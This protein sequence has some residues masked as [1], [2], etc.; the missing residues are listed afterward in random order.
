ML[1][2]QQIKQQFPIFGQYP[3]LVYLDNASTTQKPA[4]VLDAERDFYV[5][6]NANVHRGVYGLAERADD[7]YELA[8]QT[9]ADF[10]G[11]KSGQIIF[12][13]NA[14]EAAN[15]LAFGIGEQLVK[16]GDNVIVTELEHHANFLPWQEMAA[17]KQAELRVVPFL[18]ES[19]ELDKLALDR[20]INDRTRVIAVTEMSNVLGTR[21][22]LN[23]IIEHAH[24]H[25]ALAV[26][27]AAQSLPHLHTDYGKLQADAVFFTGH[28]I[29]GPMG[30]GILYVSDY[31]AETMT[32]LLTGG[33]MI[34]ELPDLWLD[35]PRKFEAGTPNVAGLV[36]L[37]DALNFVKEIGRKEI[38][39]HENELAAR[40]RKMLET[41]PQVKMFV[42]Q[43]RS[44]Q[45]SIV[46]FDLEKVHPHD[47]AS[48][49]AEDQ[50]CIRAGHHCAKPLLK[51]LGRNVLA[52][53]SLG[54][55][56]TTGDLDKLYA[57]IMKA[58]KV[59]Q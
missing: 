20:L 54:I 42:P 22:D 59:F 56:N 27:D 43:D 25:G 46:A 39:Q 40:C 17:R 52:R 29:Y 31:L 35:P 3:G 50:I 2:H 7:A 53:V 26:I 1:N 4:R 16:P 24:Q 37:A 18:E 36:G 21:P 28:K 55:Y 57:G 44:Q 41:I 33:G 9:V 5:N 23:T 47:L 10:M 8:R 32:P 6:S 11:V 15:L 34:K 38:V 45:S 49:L 48:I 51:R 13:K 14:T 19:G 12:T 58:I 30:T